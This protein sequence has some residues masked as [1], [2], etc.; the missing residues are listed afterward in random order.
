MTDPIKIIKYEN[1]SLHFRTTA[2]SHIPLLRKISGFF[3]INVVAEFGTGIYSVKTFLDKKYFPKLI[4]LYSYETSEIWGNYIKSFFDDNRWKMHFIGSQK[5]S[6]NKVDLPQNVDLIFVDGLDI[7]R[8][9]LIIKYSNLY[10]I[11]VLH[12]C[13]ADFLMPLVNKFRYKY[14]YAP[15]VPKYRHTVILS[16][17]TDVSHMK[18][19]IVWEE[20]FLKWI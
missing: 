11:F 2:G 10:N 9:P 20:D 13:D 4:N 7:Q 15:P 5:E 1:E 19:D 8:E 12:D 17:K 18:W 6:I 3:D 16:N 14:I